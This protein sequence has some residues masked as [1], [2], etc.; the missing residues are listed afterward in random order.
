MNSQFTSNNNSNQNSS[1]SSF[2]QIR[3]FTP[4]YTPTLNANNSTQFNQNLN[5][6]NNRR[7]PTPIEMN[8][9]SPQNQNP[10]PD[11]EGPRT[12]FTNTSMTPSP[13]PI[14]YQTNQLRQQQLRTNGVETPTK[15]MSVRFLNDPA[16]FVRENRQYINNN[17][18]N[19]NNSNNNNNNNNNNDNNSNLS[20][21]HSYSDTAEYSQI[22]HL[23]RDLH[24]NKLRSRSV[25]PNSPFL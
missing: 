4:P 16:A 10:Y 20:M 14:V 11:G 19:N 3:S 1:S 12:I 25:T 2:Q 5:N 13:D 8:S 7:T 24:F 17:T 6:V 22:N 23:L 9:P 15:Q 18:N 21:Q